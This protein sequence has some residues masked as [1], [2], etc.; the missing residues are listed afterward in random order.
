VTGHVVGSDF[1][2][3]HDI[4]LLPLARMG[5]TEEN[6]FATGK[7]LQT[8]KRKESAYLSEVFQ[9]SAH[10]RGTSSPR[11]QIRYPARELCFPS[12]LLRPLIEPWHLTGEIVVVEQRSGSAVASIRRRSEGEC[13]EP[14]GRFRTSRIPAG[15]AIMEHQH[16]NFFFFGDSAVG[17][18]GLDVYDRE[19]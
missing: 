6:C 9:S 17:Q 8:V 5:Y 2:D 16:A 7:S 4:D 15:D 18:L 19:Y 14:Q 10:P 12:L 3:Q 1:I 11:K 13:H